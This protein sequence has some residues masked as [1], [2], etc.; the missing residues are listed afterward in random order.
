[1]EGYLELENA[2]EGYLVIYD[3]SEQ[4]EYKSEN[5][6]IVDKEVFAVWV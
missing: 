6:M 1:M 3:K 5:I 4:K 2:D